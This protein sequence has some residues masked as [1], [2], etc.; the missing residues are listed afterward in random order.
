[1][2]NILVKTCQRFLIKPKM[3]FF[4]L[5]LLLESLVWIYLNWTCKK[6]KKEQIQAF[7]LFTLSERKQ[8]DFVEK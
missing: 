4:S 2:I 7:S 1:M 6:K 5:L 8:I 3:F